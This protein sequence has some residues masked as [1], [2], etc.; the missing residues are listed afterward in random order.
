MG[1]VENQVRSRWTGPSRWDAFFYGEVGW[2]RYITAHDIKFGLVPDT[3]T[4]CPPRQLDIT[5]IKTDIQKILLFSSSVNVQEL[6]IEFILDQKKIFSFMDTCQFTYISRD[7]F[8]PKRALGIERSWEELKEELGR[9]GPGYPNAI[10]FKTI[11]VD[12]PQLF[13]VVNDNSVF[14]HDHGQWHRY[15]SAFDIRFGSDHSVI[16]KRSKFRERR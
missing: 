2:Y 5:F 11:S 16:N 8:M 6:I 7:D 3:G 9:T 4:G 15:I 1:C 12:G 10:Y 14:Y 13:A